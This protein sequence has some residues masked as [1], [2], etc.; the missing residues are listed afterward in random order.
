MCIEQQLPVRYL[1]MI[2]IAPTNNSRIF[3]EFETNMFET[4]FRFLSS[5]YRGSGY[6]VP[7]FH[8]VVILM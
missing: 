6:L 1:H 2:T 7:T 8:L 5:C 4:F 3:V